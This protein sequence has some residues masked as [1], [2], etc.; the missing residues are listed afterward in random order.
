MFFALTTPSLLF[1]RRVSSGCSSALN[2]NPLLLA[3]GI[4]TMASPASPHLTP[5][6]DNALHLLSL[7]QSNKTIIS[8]FAA[9]PN[10]A[11]I[12]ASAIPEMKAWLA[13]AGY[14]PSDIARALR[15]IHVAGTKGKGSVCAFTSSILKQY[16]QIVGR[17][18][19]YTSPHLV[20]VR[21]RICLDGTP[22]TQAKFTTYFF[23]LWNRLS[24]AARR[25]GDQIPASD[26]LGADGPSTKPFYF[27][28]LTLLAL[29]AFIREGVTSAVIEC[30]IGG[31]YDSTNVLPPE[32]VTASV[33]TQ[34]GVD[35][36]N[37]LGDT[38]EKIAWH[39]AGIF[40]KGV[41]AYTYQHGRHMDESDGVMKVLSGRAEE[42]GTSLTAIEDGFVGGWGG[43]EDARLEGGFQ[44]GNM[45]LASVVARRHLQSF[46]HQIDTTSFENDA[47]P[48]PTNLESLP[49][50]FITGLQSASLRGRCE[51]LT[52]DRIAWYLDG[53]HT[54]DSLTQVAKWFASKIV[55]EDSIRVLVFNQQDR[56]STALLQT[57]LE[58][59]Q[60]ETNIPNRKIFH[61][62]FCPTNDLTSS[63]EKP[64][65]TV[66]RKNCDVVRQF[67]PFTT[68]VPAD[69]VGFALE[70]ARNVMLGS[71][72]SKDGFKVQVLVTGSFNLVGPALRLLDPSSEL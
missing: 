20:S 4:L 26:P 40:K 9:S 11:D 37:M 24:D 58:A 55:S 54:T 35:H 22:I 46:Q 32:A 38:V 25:E 10:A 59:L 39:K 53:A 52:Q 18:G 71:K 67:C 30:G 60:S 14:S 19:T 8:L 41:A 63:G 31:E 42:K 33:V 13:R 50:P 36:V 70:L 43:V 69:S 47:A 68:A 34:L 45:A 72:K 7:L 61:H 49:A 29:H 2:F 56:D 66:Q 51:T 5:T 6:Y 21:E 57:L 3:R 28:F 1:S 64:D 17:V 62:A 48:L 16:P 12:N 15:V 65:M 44:Q 23:E 27:R